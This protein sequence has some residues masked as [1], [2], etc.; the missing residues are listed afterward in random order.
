MCVNTRPRS[1]H[2]Q[3]NSVAVGTKAARVRFDPTPLFAKH[4]ASAERARAVLTSPANRTM[5]IP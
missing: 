5:A 4:A 3:A 2:V 1:A